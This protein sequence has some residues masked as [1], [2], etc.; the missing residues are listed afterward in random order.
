V[1]EVDALVEPAEELAF[2]TVLFAAWAAWVLDDLT[3]TEL[4]VTAALP[5]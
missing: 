1:L 5:F 4:A 2:V 3:V